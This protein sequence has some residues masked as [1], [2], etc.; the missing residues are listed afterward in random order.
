MALLSQSDNSS[1]STAGIL[2]FGIIGYGGVSSTATSN[3][4]TQAQL[5]AVN[6]L[7]AGGNLS[8]IAQGTDETTSNSTADGGGV[9]N[10]GASNA[11]ADESPT[12]TGCPGR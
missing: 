1:D 6:G 12:V 10:I 4:T 5:N 2:N 11:T 9:L 3:G 8:A 7:L